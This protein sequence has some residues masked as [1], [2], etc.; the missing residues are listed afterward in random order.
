MAELTPLLP[1]SAVRKVVQIALDALVTQTVEDVLGS[2]RGVSDAA[3][4]WDV[5]ERRARAHI[6][7]IHKIHHVGWRV[8]AG[9][10]WVITQGDIEAHP[11]DRRYRSKSQGE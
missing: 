3:K 9:G 6:E 7:R 10:T 1:S 2:L 11:P 8:G 4:A 5:N